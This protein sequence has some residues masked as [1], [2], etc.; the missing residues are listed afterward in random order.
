MKIHLRF[1]ERTILQ[2]LLNGESLR[3]LDQKERLSVGPALD[4]DDL[5][6]CT[7]AE[8]VILPCLACIHCVVFLLPGIV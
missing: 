6:N 5:S 4:A 2:D 8:E 1:E 3:A 7:I